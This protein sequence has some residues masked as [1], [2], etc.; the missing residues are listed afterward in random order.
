MKSAGRGEFHCVLSLLHI[1]LFRDEKQKE[2]KKLQATSKEDMWLADLDEFVAK[3]DEV[4]G[5]E[6]KETK[7]GQ[8]TQQK[9]FKKV[10]G[11]KGQ[12][13]AETQPSAHGIRI[14]PRIADDLKE[15]AA[16]ATAAKARKADKA[17]GKAAKKKVMH[18]VD[19]FD[20]MTDGKDMNT[21]LSKKLGNTPDAIMRNKSKAAKG[22][23]KKKGKN[24]W[25]DSD[26]EDVDGSDLSDA[27]DDAP[28]IPRE[29]AAGRRAAANIKFDKYKSDEES[30]GSDDEMF[31]NSGIDEE[32]AKPKKKS[33]PTY[34]VSSDEDE[35][36]K[37]AAP[38]KQAAITV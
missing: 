8:E 38:K 18:E 37:K 23:G 36:P 5:K 7:E 24:P 26:G 35:P 29:K 10:A 2:L 32:P 27:M 12:V 31:E 4:E 15:K 19:E 11:K 17:E 14:E 16:K 30:E 34:D 22:S 13:K 28:V 25:S 33:E 6:N 9:G 1:L 3:L 21:S 20:M